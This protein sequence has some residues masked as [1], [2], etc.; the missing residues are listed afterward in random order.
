MILQKPQPNKNLANPEYVMYESYN[1]KNTG[2][3]KLITLIICLFITL[4][5]I[6][7]CSVRGMDN[8]PSEIE[9]YLNLG[10]KALQQDEL[11]DLVK[12]SKQ[13]IETDMY[14]PIG[15]LGYAIVW[16]ERGNAE[17]ALS[18]L[19][20]SLHGMKQFYQTEMEKLRL[21]IKTDQYTKDIGIEIYK[22]CSDYYIET[23]Q[24]DGE[25]VPDLKT[26]Y[27][28]RD[29]NG[30]NNFVLGKIDNLGRKQGFCVVNIF[31][32]TSFELVS[33]VE[34]EFIDDLAEGFVKELRVSSDLG[35]K[36]EINF[37]IANGFF[38]NGRRDGLIEIN[39]YDYISRPEYVEGEIIR[40]IDCK[41]SELT[42]AYEGLC[43]NGVYEDNTGKAYEMWIEPKE[44]YKIWYVGQFKDGHQHGY[45]KLWNEKSWLYEGRFSNDVPVDMKYT[46]DR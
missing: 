25:I 33:I 20:K 22:R 4:I 11:N 44:G 8:E 2:H 23:I 5:L 28:Y 17:Y 38:L 12:I 34:G 9:E 45:G 30:D 46:D 14:C 24:S 41:A 13:I 29:E 21:Y 43:K 7:G 42:Y 35:E 36:G 40:V 31:D 15:Y 6:S 39:G 3:D 16:M 10:Y 27:S 19:D 37:E 32:K 1:N 26:L 18:V